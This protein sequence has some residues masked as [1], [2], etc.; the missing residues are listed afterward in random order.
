MLQR[1]KISQYK[2]ENAVLRKEHR[3][4]LIFLEIKIHLL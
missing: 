4:S 2:K 3:K 1:R